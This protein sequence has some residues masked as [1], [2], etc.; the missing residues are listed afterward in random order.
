MQEIM[1][2]LWINT[3]DLLLLLLCLNSKSFRVVVIA[4]CKNHTREISLEVI[5]LIFCVECQEATH[6]REEP[7]ADKNPSTYY[8]VCGV[9]GHKF[10][11]IDVNELFSGDSYG[12]F[13]DFDDGDD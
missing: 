9:C 5:M 13:C 4:W 12:A 2:L 11:L 3:L 1:F 8:R 7:T 10:Y 6:S